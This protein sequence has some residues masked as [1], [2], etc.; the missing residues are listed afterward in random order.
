MTL[1]GQ[2]ALCCT[3]D[4]SFGAHCTN[5]NELITYTH[6]S[7]DTNEGQWLVSG[8]I[9]CMRIFAG[10]PLGGGV[11]SE[12]G[13]LRQQFLAN[14][15]A[16]SSETSEIILYD[17]MLPVVGLWLNYTLRQRARKLQAAH[18]V[19]PKHFQTGGRIFQF[20]MHA[21]AVVG[22]MGL[23]CSLRVQNIL[24]VMPRTFGSEIKTPFD[25]RF[26][27]RRIYA[28]S[29]LRFSASIQSIEGA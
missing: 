4:A 22:E 27:R 8:N 14:W 19:P 17:D 26:V 11:K 15:V 12:C 18:T 25:S 23:V 9:R 2:N 16:T 3:N 1:H 29:T 21:A 6:T 28:V 10:V 7:S 20:E 13:C 5:L 24:F